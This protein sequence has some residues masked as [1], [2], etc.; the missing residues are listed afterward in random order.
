MYASAQA[1][2]QPRSLVDQPQDPSS[3]IAVC[4]FGS[5]HNLYGLLECLQ[6]MQIFVPG[7]AR[8]TIPSL[9]RAPI[10]SPWLLEFI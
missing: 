8:H 6:L 7:I 3:L 5:L 4:G 2:L 9:R 10:C 1:A